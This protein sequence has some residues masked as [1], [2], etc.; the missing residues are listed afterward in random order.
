METSVLNRLDKTAAAFPDKVMFRDET[1]EITFGE[2]DRLT[3]AVGTYLSQRVPAGSP[4]AVMSGRHILT[5]SCFLGAVRAGC[6]YAPMDGD[7][8]Q[9][10]LNQIIGVIRAGFMLVDRAHLETAQAL[11]FDGEIIVFED[12]RDTEP[13][14]AL[15]AA[16]EKT[17]GCTSPLY[18]IFTS[19]STGVPKG[20]ITSHQSLMT[21]IDSV[22]KVLDIN[23]TDILGNQSP[24]DYIAAVRDI[25]FPVS[26]GASTYI[27][28]KNEF[29]VPTT[30]FD[31]L[32]REKITALCWSVAGVELPAKLGAFDVSK[33]EYL[34]KLCF[35]GSVMP[36]KYLKIW[37]E[38]MPDV[39]YVNQYGP[40]EA[41]ASCT[42]YVVKEKV[43]DDT[44]LPIGTAYDNYHVMLLNEDNTA[45]PQGETGE[46]CVSGPILALGYYGNKEQTEKS[47][48]QNPLNDNYRELIYKTGDLGHFDENGVLHF[49]GR[50]DRQIKHLG[51]RIELGEIEET[52]K[53]IAGVTDCCALYYKDKATL[54][55]FYVGPATSKEIVL[56][57]RQNMPAFMVPRK[58]INLEALPTLPNG[59]TDMQ[60]LKSYFK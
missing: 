43:N 13:D 49:H 36:C 8:P 9:T 57:F 6:F 23:S 32:N 51:H 37:Q 27:I 58:L 56:Y 52:A 25:Y 31:T 4:V 2:F 34:R 24:L 22:A 48:L 28:P 39:L 29:A 16:R 50:K 17:L 21:Y 26:F 46:I 5:P 35:S 38:H 47:F 18:V 33:P 1:A 41:T 19:G 54:Y 44:V 10:R 45:T 15:L 60:T 3:K 7:M 59:K 42:Y 55:L 14:E 11:D 12:I 30:L 53:K 40:T 20:V